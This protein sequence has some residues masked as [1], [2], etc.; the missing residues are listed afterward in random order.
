MFDGKSQK[1][2]CGIYTCSR[3]TVDSPQK[4]AT[5]PELPKVRSH[6]DLSSLKASASWEESVHFLATGVLGTALLFILPFSIK[7]IVTLSYACY[8]QIQGLLVQYA[9]SPISFTL[10][11]RR[12]EDAAARVERGR[13]RV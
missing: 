11:F 1:A 7:T 10:D 3:V 8:L 12:A 13:G 6:R 9:P 4:E 5:R 2:G